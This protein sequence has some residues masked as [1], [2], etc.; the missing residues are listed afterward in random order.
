MIN[1]FKKRYFVE[2]D[3]EIQDNFINVRL[4]DDSNKCTIQSY[5]NGE[6]GSW[7]EFDKQQ[8]SYLIHILE[9][10]KREMVD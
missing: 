3:V 4:N 9:L 8:L 2:N 6:A 10:K 7:I 5:I 1:I